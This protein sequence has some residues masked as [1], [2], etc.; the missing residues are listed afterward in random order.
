[1]LLACVRTW[2]NEAL[3]KALLAS[4]AHCTVLKGFSSSIRIVA[5]VRPGR[6]TPFDADM[7]NEVR[8]GDSPPGSVRGAF[9]KRLVG[10]AEKAPR[11]KYWLSVV[12]SL[13]RPVTS[14]GL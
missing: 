14:A 3:P 10:V 12:F 9:P 11:L 1:M 6:S 13:M 8:K 4:A 2:P 5:A 7:L